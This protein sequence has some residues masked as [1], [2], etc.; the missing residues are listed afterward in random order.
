[1]LAQESKPFLCIDSVEH[2]LY[3]QLYIYTVF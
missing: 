2:P 3:V 1:M